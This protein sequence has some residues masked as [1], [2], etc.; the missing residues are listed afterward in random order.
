LLKNSFDEIIQK[1]TDFCRW[2]FFAKVSSKIFLLLG[3]ALNQNYFDKRIKTIHTVQHW[4]CY[5]QKPDNSRSRIRG[6]V[7]WQ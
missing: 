5:T 3:S 7:S 2:F 1:T 6:D 4:A